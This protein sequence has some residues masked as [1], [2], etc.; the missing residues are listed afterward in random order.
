MVKQALVHLG[1]SVLQLQYAL[2]MTNYRDGE[3]AK[4]WGGTT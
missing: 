2:E 3:E 1:S 4:P